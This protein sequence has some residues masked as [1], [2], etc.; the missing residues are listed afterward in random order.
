VSEIETRARQ[1]VVAKLREQASANREIARILS[2]TQELVQAA[3]HRAMADQFDRIADEQEA[4]H[5]A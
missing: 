1:R 4:R 5:G 3:T 2:P